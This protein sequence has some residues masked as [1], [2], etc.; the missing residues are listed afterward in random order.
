MA[1]WFLVVMFV[2]RG[3][4]VDPSFAKKTACTGSN[5]RTLCVTV[6][7]CML[8]LRFEW[9]MDIRSEFLNKSPSLLH[10]LL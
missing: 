1:R 2:V 9:R 6:V 8:M 4:H 3:G 10:M 5:K 7:C